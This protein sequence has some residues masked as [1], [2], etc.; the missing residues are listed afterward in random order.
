MKDTGSQYVPKIVEKVNMKTIPLISC[1][2]AANDLDIVIAQK[3]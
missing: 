1:V 3:N 2:F